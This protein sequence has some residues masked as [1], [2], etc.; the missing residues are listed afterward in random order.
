MKLSSSQCK[1]RRKAAAK[2]LKKARKRGEITRADA[3]KARVYLRRQ[4]DGADEVLDEICEMAEDEEYSMPAT[5]ANG[6]R[7]WDEFFDGL[8]DFAKEIMEN[9]PSLIGLCVV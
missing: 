2:Q 4:P 6:E 3:L 1:A 5:D 8:T 9:L 7:N